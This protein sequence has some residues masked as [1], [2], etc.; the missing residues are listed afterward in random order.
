MVLG[1]LAGAVAEALMQLNDKLVQSA[2]LAL[3]IPTF[4]RRMHDNGRSG[5]WALVPAIGLVPRGHK[6]AVPPYGFDNLWPLFL[7]PFFFGGIY[8]L[9][10][11]GKGDPSRYGLDPRVV[12]G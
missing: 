1:A 12:R 3:V 6:I 7:A 2:V 8:L 9:V 4:A 11:A 10:R 5:W